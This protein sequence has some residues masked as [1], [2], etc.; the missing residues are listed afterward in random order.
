MTTKAA[1]RACATSTRDARRKRRP[2]PTPRWLT[3]AQD[4]D[5][6]AK[7]RCLLVLRVLSGEMPVTDA[8]EEAQISRQMYYLLEERALRAMLAALLPGASAQTTSGGQ[9][10]ARRVAELEA[11]VRTLEQ[12]KR[13]SERLLLLTRKV[14]RAKPV[15]T[16][17]RR[18][19]PSSTSAGKRPSPSSKKTT[20]PMPVAPISSTPTPAGGDGR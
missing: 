2:R 7:S 16:A 17:G 15:T 20:R 8:I 12:Y 11:Q 1:R 19:S 9:G 6:V 5:E 3:K 18:A 10:W 14:V 4:L 13:R